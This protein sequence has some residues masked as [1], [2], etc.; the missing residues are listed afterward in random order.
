MPPSGSVSEI[1]I[2]V[3]SL[4]FRS[5]VLFAEA[6]VAGLPATEGVPARQL[7]ELEKVGGP[8]RGL[9]SSQ[10]GHRGAFPT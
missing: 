5:L 7:P 10:Q 2:V 4:A 8:V 6:T 3:K 9:L 1:L